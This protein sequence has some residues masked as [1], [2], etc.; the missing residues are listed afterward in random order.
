MKYLIFNSVEKK[1]Q[2][3]RVSFEKFHKITLIQKDIDEF[4]LFIER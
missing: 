3:A 4:F 2:I 1:Y